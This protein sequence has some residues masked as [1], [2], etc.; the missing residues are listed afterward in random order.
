[1]VKLVISTVCMSGKS[2]VK[3]MFGKIMKMTDWGIFD[4]LAHRTL[5]RLSL[6]ST[7]YTM[8]QRILIHEH[9]NSY[10]FR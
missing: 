5:H 3:L 7:Q 6:V 1:M 2:S 8:Y 10:W 9:L 4:A